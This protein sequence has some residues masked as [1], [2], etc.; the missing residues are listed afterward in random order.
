[1][2]FSGRVYSKFAVRLLGL[3]IS[4]PVVANA[5]RSLQ[6]S[7]SPVPDEP[8]QSKSAPQS[9]SDSEVLDNDAIIKMV[10][11]K[12]SITI[13]KN[14]IRDN[15]GHYSLT[16]ISLIRLGNAGV[17]QPIIEA[18]QEK[19]TGGATASPTPAPSSTSQTSISLSSQWETISGRDV[20]TGEQFVKA[21]KNYET[22][23]GASVQ[24]TASCQVDT[25]RQNIANTLPTAHNT[26]QSFMNFMQS[27]GDKELPKNPRDE[28]IQFDARTLDF[29]LLYHPKPGSSLSLLHTPI[30]IGQGLHGEAE[31]GLCVIMRVNVD[32]S[33]RDGIQSGICNI[34]NLASISFPAMHFRDV[35]GYQLGYDEHNNDA[36]NLVGNLIGG[37][38]TQSADIMEQDKSKSLALMHDAI[39]SN[40]ILIELPISNGEHSIVDIQPQDPMFRQFA[41]SCFSTFPD[42]PKPVMKASVGGPLG[43]GMKPATL[44]LPLRGPNSHVPVRGLMVMNIYPDGPSNWA[45][46]HLDLITTVNSKPVTTEE[47]V[48]NAITSVHSRT[49]ILEI[50]REDKPHGVTVDINP[51]TPADFTAARERAVTNQPIPE[52]PYAPTIPQPIAPISVAPY[53]LGGI[54]ASLNAEVA[55]PKNPNK[56]FPVV[57]TGAQL[58]SA[59]DNALWIPDGDPTDK[60]IYV[61]AETCSETSQAFYRAT[62]QLKGIQLRWIET[63]PND[64]PRCYGYLGEIATYPDPSVLVKM[65]DTYADPQPAAT[66][67]R[68]NAFRWNDG[69]EGAVYDIVNSIGQ[70]DKDNFEFPTVVWLSNEGV[71]A[72]IRPTNLDP[73]IAS[74]VP[75]PSATNITP[76]GRSFVNAPFQIQTIPKTMFYAKHDN[77]PLYSFP[78]TKSELINTLD[79][80]RGYE[81]IHRVSVSGV[82]WIELAI[83]G[84]GSPGLFVRESD[85][86]K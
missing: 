1:V 73:I 27:M 26:E 46:R 31:G 32:G 59:L 37:V 65:Y 24:V 4:L 84:E 3:I 41:A 76:L 45:F 79:K 62:R 85:V 39:D 86:T 54:V 9:N 57:K 40:H 58:L 28:K 25:N 8:Q 19:A 34:A 56:A 64:G 61:F 47:E 83:R 82:N 12:L 75:R 7:Q 71:R 49:A 14:S 42:P 78:D 44:D 70:H 36:Q 5:T 15:P 68:D 43:I 77:T 67:L 13:I 23:A 69:V 48:L 21:S 11:A 30:Q 2:K 66:A 29:K 38:M 52:A 20:M 74:V 51:V 53:R 17:P 33:I 6:I 18:M 81:S 60:Q 55:I 50:Y 10:Q 22:Q 35:M 80:G 63:T 16:A 72:A